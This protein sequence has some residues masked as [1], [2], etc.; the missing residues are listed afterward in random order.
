MTKENLVS[1]VKKAAVEAVEAT[2][3]VTILFGT[4]TSNSP[5]QVTIDQK[6]ILTEPHFVKNALLL[7]GFKVG[8]KLILFRLKGGQRF[9]ISEVL[10][11]EAEE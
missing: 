10:P 11:E 8:A 6:M 5:L 7:G 2:K 4:V 3:P 1:L 9:L